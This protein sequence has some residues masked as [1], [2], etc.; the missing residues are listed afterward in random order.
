MKNLSRPL[1]AFTLVELVAVVAILSLLAALVVR[2]QED[3]QHRTERL[4]CMSNLKDR[5]YAR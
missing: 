4:Q 5:C 1:R 2:A 3:T